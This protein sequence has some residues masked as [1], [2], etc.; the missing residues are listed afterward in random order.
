MRPGLWKKVKTAHQ[1]DA[2]WDATFCITTNASCTQVPRQVHLVAWAVRKLQKET[3]APWAWASLSVFPEIGRQGRQKQQKC[4]SIAGTVKP[5]QSSQLTLLFVVSLVRFSSS[6]AK[7]YFYWICCIY[8]IESL[9][10]FL[11][12][13]SYFFQNQTLN[14]SF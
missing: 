12:F 7:I 4:L 11:K 3:S 14:M 6:Q 1:E 8:I 13:K 2:S 9:F 5:Y 10:L